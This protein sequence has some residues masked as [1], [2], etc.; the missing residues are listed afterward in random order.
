MSSK[1]A[2]NLGEWRGIDGNTGGKALRLPAHH[3]VTH[4]VIVGMTMT[5]T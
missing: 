5:V 3:L 2:L 1:P 4:S